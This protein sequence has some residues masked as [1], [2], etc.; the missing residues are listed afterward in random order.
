[1]LMNQVK[2]AAVLL[3]VGIGS[4]YWAWRAA[5]AASDDKEQSPP[6]QAR[7]RPPIG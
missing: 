5:G 2:V 7:L 3:F 1:M 4:S 6:R